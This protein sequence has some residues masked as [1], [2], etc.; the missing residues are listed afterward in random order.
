MWRVTDL[1][2][3]HLGSCTGTQQLRGLPCGAL[4]RRGASGLA[5]RAAMVAEPRSVE[6]RAPDGS[7]A[8]TESLSLRV[9][10]PEVANGL[11]H[12]YVVFLRQNMRRVRPS[13]RWCRIAA[14]QACA[15]W[16]AAG[17]GATMCCRALSTQC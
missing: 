3:C 2:G 4:P 1:R 13:K 8:G 10:E 6:V 7:A 16:D 5:L 11:V 17:L 15:C 9:A 14:H 12:R